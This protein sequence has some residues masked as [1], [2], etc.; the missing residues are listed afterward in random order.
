MALIVSAPGTIAVAGRG[1]WSWVL[2]TQAAET[3]TAAATTLR[4]RCNAMVQPAYHQGCDHLPRAR[5]RRAG[6]APRQ[7]HAGGCRSAVALSRGRGAR[8]AAGA[9]QGRQRRGLGRGTRGG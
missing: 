5:L 2:G 8:R 7:P 6:Y 4:P 1:A 9:N 3:R